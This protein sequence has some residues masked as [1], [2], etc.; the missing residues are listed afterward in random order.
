VRESE[1]VRKRKRERERKMTQ[2]TGKKELQ[3]SETSD[4]RKAS[5]SSKTG[6]FSPLFSL[7]PPVQC[8][9]GIVNQEFG[10]K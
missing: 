8:N 7:A 2:I 4:R 5:P 6:R 3:R 1:K 9:D 10:F